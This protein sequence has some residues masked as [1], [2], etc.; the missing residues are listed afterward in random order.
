LTPAVAGEGAETVRLFFALWPEI[1]VRHELAAWQKKLQ[2]G[3]SAQAQRPW[4]LHLT[5]AFLGATPVAQ[6]NAVKDAAAGARGKLFDL[7]LDVAGFWPHNQ[8]AWVG[9]STPP[10]ALQ[11]LESVLRTRL[12]D[13][14]IKFDAKAFHPHVSLLRGVRNPKPEWPQATVIW[15]ARDFV[16]VESQPGKYG[17]R[18]E[19]VARFPLR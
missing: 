8:I 12:T 18:Y 2:Q 15:P 7:L 14:G 17:S 6:L 16:L 3:V 10:P 13:A 5:L 11:D 19:I 9:T 1:G 4:T